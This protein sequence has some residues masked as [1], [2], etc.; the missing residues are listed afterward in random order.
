LLQGIREDDPE[1][2]AVALSHDGA[3][4]KVTVTSRAK[5]A[6]MRFDTSGFYTEEQMNENESILSDFI[7]KRV[8]KAQ[9][10][11]TDNEWKAIHQ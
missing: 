9:L 6:P 7:H 11:V 4:T 5:G 2:C 3:N 10:F 1:L 8:E